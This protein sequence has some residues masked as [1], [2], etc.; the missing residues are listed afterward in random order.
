MGPDDEGPGARNVTELNVLALAAE[1]LPWVFKRTGDPVVA[2]AV[3]GLMDHPD[4][5]VRNAALRHVLVLGSDYRARAWE[6]LERAVSDE[7]W[8]VVQRAGSVFDLLVEEDAARAWAG[9]LAVYDRLTYEIITDFTVNEIRR[10][11][12]WALAGQADAIARLAA[13]LEDPWANPE[14]SKLFAFVLTTRLGPPT[15]AAAAIVPY[16]VTFIDRLSAQLESA[17][18]AHGDKAGP[19]PERDRAR[20]KTSGE[21]LAEI[22]NRVEVH[23]GLAY[24]TA[25][26]DEPAARLAHYRVLLPVLEALARAPLPHT[27]LSRR[28]YDR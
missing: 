17:A 6:V 4:S 8:I 1:T 3:L 11:I 12:D 15:P 24:N 2:E 28:E 9:R 26:F 13:I 18:A 5:Y 16:L 19:E 20:S 21:I 7:S 23:S 25:R 27:R 14:L 10:L 22:A